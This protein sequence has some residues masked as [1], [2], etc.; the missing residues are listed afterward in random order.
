MQR[1]RR[2]TP[3]P[4]TWEIPVGI[5][6]AVLLALVLGLQAGRSLANLVVGNG[7]VFVDR[8]ALFTTLAPIV[9][10]QAGAG[11]PAVGHPATPGL[12]WACVGVVELL[13]VLVMTWAVKSGLDR[14][15]PARLRGMATATEAEALLGRTRLRRHAKVIRPDL[16]GAPRGGRR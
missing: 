5:V 11:L 12:L 1:T 10:G 2:T 4:F 13:V 9:S 14:W 3:Y 8:L 16:Y 6:F 15:G 7:W